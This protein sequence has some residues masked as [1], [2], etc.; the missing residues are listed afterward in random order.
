MGIIKDLF[1]GDK[2]IWIIFLCFCLISIVEVF[3]AGSFLAY[4]IDNHLKPI[5][6][7][8]LFL[9]VGAVIVLIVHSIPCRHFIK[10]PIPLYAISLFLLILVLVSPKVNGASRWFELFG[11]TFQPSE[12]GKMAV[13]LM[14]ALFLTKCRDENGATKSAFKYILLF[15]GVI[16]CLIFPENFSTA[17]ILFLVVFLMM[18]VGKVP[19]KLLATLA[20]SIVLLGAILIGTVM[21]IP[22]KKLSNNVFT[23]RVGTWQQRIKDFAEDKTAVPAAKYDTRNNTQVA[24]A[25]IAIA[26]SHLIGKLPGNSVQR[27][28]LPQA[29]SDFIFA[30]IIE[31]LGLLGGAF[32]ILLYICLLVRINKIAKQSEKFFPTYLIMGIGL[33][34]VLQAMV[35]M[36]VSVGF[37]P[38]TGQPLPLISRGGTSI[39]V[40]CAYI[41]MVLSVSRYVKEKQ[42]EKEETQSL[43]ADAKLKEATE[44]L[45]T[46][47]REW[48]TSNESYEEKEYE[49]K[50]SSQQLS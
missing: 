41:G 40:N 16:I 25:N 27:D 35:N 21:V 6:G 4:N 30:I 38:V 44:V 18:V 29:F 31:E 45:L 13:V 10:F 43:E 26:S 46:H 37:F 42:L 36:M 8:S 9:L 50:Q 39:L 22:T 14:T 33:L 47:A 7:H 48:V 28:F 12:L 2:I 3:S 11:V 32:V 1:K 15:N 5:E 23:H 19:W 49:D 34:F 20:V 17:M 24:H